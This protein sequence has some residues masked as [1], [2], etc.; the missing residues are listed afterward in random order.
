MKNILIL[1]ISVILLL[2][3]SEKSNQITKE[4]FK[5]INNG[6]NIVVIKEKFG[7]PDETKYMPMKVKWWIYKRLD[8]AIAIKDDTVS[9]VSLSAEKDIAIVET[10]FNAFQKGAKELEKSL[11]SLKTE[12]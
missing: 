3:C 12:K 10:L 2:G 7:K 4:D 1:S 8:C 11:D 9:N 6:T 5:K